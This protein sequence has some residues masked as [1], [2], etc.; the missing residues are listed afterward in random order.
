MKLPRDVSGDRL[1]RLLE[2]LGYRLTRQRGSHARLKHDG[3]PT[4]S[5]TVPRHKRLKT[6]TPQPILAEIARMR[7][8]TIDSLVDAL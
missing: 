3:P 5:I 8:V 1:I 2:D 6:G 7:S 4:H